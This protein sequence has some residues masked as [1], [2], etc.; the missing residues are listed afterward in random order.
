ME[1]SFVKREDIFE[2]IDELFVQ[3]VEH[4]SDKE[5][6][7]RPLPRLTYDDLMAR[8]GSDKPDL[9]FDMELYD[10]TNI[11]KSTEFKV[12]R[13]A[14]QVKGIRAPGCA[15]PQPGADR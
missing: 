7:F 9:R 6:K 14:E 4:C 5:L 3:I 1:M 13:T 10:I 2:I 15:G 8:Y 11:A 12:F